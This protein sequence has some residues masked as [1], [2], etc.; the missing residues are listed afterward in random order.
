MPLSACVRMHTC[1]KILETQL[2]LQQNTSIL[3]DNKGENRLLCHSGLTE[4][5]IIWQRLSVF[6]QL[7]I[8][9]SVNVFLIQSVLSLWN[10][11]DSVSKLCVQTVHQLVFPWYPSSASVVATFKLCLSSIQ[12]HSIQINFYIPLFFTFIYIP[13]LIAVIYPKLL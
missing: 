3:D 7:C 4:I 11:D 8:T 10:P 2:R 9:L 6:N 12:K 5:L 1:V 13:L